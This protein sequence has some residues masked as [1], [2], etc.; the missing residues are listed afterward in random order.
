MRGYFARSSALLIML[1]AA[2]CGGDAT[3]R[4]PSAS[5]G[6]PSPTAVP[7]V[8]AAAPPTPGIGPPREV[9][10]VTLYTWST[11]L[12]EDRSLCASVSSEGPYFQPSAFSVP[13]DALPHVS[14]PDGRKPSFP[15]A[16]VDRGVTAFGFFFEPQTYVLLL[17]GHEWPVAIPLDEAVATSVGARPAVLI[18]PREPNL[19]DGVTLIVPASAG[20]LVVNGYNLS[21]DQALAMAAA[22]DLDSLQIPKAE[23][24]FTGVLNG[25]EFNDPVHFTYGVCRNGYYGLDG[26][27]AVT[28]PPKDARLNIEPSY[29]P[30]GVS[31]HP[32]PQIGPSSA[33]DVL[34][35]GDIE[36]VQRGYGTGG[37]YWIVRKSGLPEW[38]SSFS[39]DWYTEITVAGLPAVLV[40]APA[41]LTNEK[42]SQVFIR[43]EFGL[44]MVRAPDAADVLKIAEGLNC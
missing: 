9:N 20:L 25:I 14:L 4:S 2:A 26:G 41:A 30:P 35:C 28:G 23:P 3:T 27:Q 18:R 8:T 22:I 24:R 43:E 36:S 40:E 10:G 15:S 6:S 42:W 17:S 44:T 13:E 33:P 37:Q 7:T 38:Y 16:C 34:M 19:Q 1:G 21:A 29:L 12:S 11:W 32:D 39:R 31:A 5:P